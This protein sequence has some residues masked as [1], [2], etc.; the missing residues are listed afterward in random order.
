MTVFV[1]C[2][3]PCCLRIFLHWKLETIESEKIFYCLY[4]Y[5]K[6]MSLFYI[7]F[8]CYC[9]RFLKELRERGEV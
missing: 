9:S 7:V 1:R 2:Y 3:V 8:E 4:S 5:E 6:L